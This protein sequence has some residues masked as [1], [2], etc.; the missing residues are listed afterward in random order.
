MEAVHIVGAS[1]GYG[2]PLAGAGLGEVGHYVDCAVVCV[3][4]DVQ[5]PRRRFPVLLF[6]CKETR[7]GA[8]FVDY[9]NGNERTRYHL[10]LAVTW[11]PLFFPGSGRYTL[12]AGCSRLVANAI[13]VFYVVWTW[14]GQLVYRCQRWMC[15]NH[16][17]AEVGHTVMRVIGCPMWCG[18]CFSESQQSSRRLSPAGRGSEKALLRRC[19]KLAKTAIQ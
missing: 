16:A 8:S 18:A 4:G 13:V 15:G 14:R 9:L 5:I 19:S 3:C 17:N 10:A 11:P 6:V 2:R 7:G 1:L 12:P